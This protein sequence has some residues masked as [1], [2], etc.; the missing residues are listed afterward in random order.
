VAKEFV[1]AR[2][3][4][5]G[6]LV[7]SRFTGAAQELAGAVPINPSAVDEFAEALRQALVLPG[8][9]QG[10]RLRRMR[11]QVADNNIYR[12]AGMLL[13]EAGGPV[14]AGAGRAPGRHRQLAR[15]GR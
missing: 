15:P 11:Q 10:R 12:W 7:L 2:A 5:R 13:A 4:L 3:D 14:G 8:E 9:E 1:A 6:V